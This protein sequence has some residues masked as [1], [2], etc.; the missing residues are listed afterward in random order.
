[1]N[2]PSTPFLQQLKEQLAIYYADFDR[3]KPKRL[4]QLEKEYKYV[5]DSQ[6]DVIPVIRDI[7]ISHLL[8]CNEVVL[9]HL[10]AEYEKLKVMIEQL[11]GGYVNAKKEKVNGIKDMKPFGELMTN[12]KELVK[13]L[14][15]DL[16]A[17]KQKDI[18]HL[19][20]IF[21]IDINLIS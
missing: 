20:R 3:I 8:G 21:N 12:M 2:Y 14:N 10:E 9:P 15:K 1:M 4:N 17:M 19:I 5:Y 7:E 6:Y 13:L 18:S 16:E 11:K